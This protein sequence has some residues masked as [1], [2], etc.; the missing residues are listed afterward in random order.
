MS[1]CTAQDVRDYMGLSSSAAPDAVLD[2]LCAA[3]EA[4]VLSYLG[5]TSLTVASYTETLHGNGADRITPRNTPI[6]TVTSVTVDGVAVPAATSVTG[7][8]F[9]YDEL[10]IYW[11]GGRFGKGIANVQIVYSAGFDTVPEDIKRAAIDIVGEKFTRRSRIG[12][13]SKN[14]GQESITYRADDVTP[15]AKQALARY[16]RHLM[17]TR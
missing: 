12:V 10:C 1:I 13:Q 11:R 4:F 5:R 15:F 16:R 8:G 6:K 9:V 3:A 7:D 17:V 2:P 14:I